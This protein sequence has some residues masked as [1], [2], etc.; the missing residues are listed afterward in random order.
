MMVEKTLRCSDGCFSVTYSTDKP[1]LLLKDAHQY[2]DPVDPETFLNELGTPT[3]IA[4]N[5]DDR[6]PNCGEPLTVDNRSETR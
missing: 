1:Q 4:R 2:D 6:C 5:A 3:R